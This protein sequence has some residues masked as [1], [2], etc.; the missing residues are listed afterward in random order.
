MTGKPCRH[1]AYPNGTYGDRD[2][3][4]CEKAGYQSARTV[5]AGWNDIRTDPYRLKSMVVSDKAAVSL[6]ALSLTGIPMYFRYLKK[7]SWNGKQP[8]L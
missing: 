4:L 6:L 5:D 3:A 1:F 8:C 7:G 2:R